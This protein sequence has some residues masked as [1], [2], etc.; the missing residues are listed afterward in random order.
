MGSTNESWGINWQIGSEN[1]PNFVF[2]T[3][4]LL[5]PNINE[6]I[7]NTGWK[8]I[9]HTIENSL[10]KKKLLNFYLDQEDQ[11]VYVILIK[12]TILQEEV[13]VMN[14]HAPITGKKSTSGN[15]HYLIKQ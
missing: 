3:R 9:F 10:K 6:Q 13:T 11:I 4:N 7:K 2:Y 1:E 12:G 5:N 15:K 14:I 8:T